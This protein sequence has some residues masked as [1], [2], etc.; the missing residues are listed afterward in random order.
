M[1]C[2]VAIG[3]VEPG[4]LHCPG[5]RVFT[6]LTGFPFHSTKHVVMIFLSTHRRM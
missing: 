5:K 2:H 3:E 1:C 6:D 4:D